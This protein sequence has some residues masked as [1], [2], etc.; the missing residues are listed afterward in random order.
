MPVVNHVVLASGAVVAVS[1]AVAAAMA[2]YENPELR[3]YAD[4][5]RRRIAVALHSLGDG[6]NPPNR[7]PRFNRPEDAEGFLQSSRGA[8]AEPGVDAD[9]ETRRR[10]REELLYWNSVLEQKKEQESARDQPAGL[11]APEPSRPRTGTRGTSFDD[12]LRQDESAEQGAY[13]FNTGADIRD[14]GS[15][16]R[17]RVPAAAPLASSSLYTNPFADEHYISNDEVDPLSRTFT[18]PRKEEHMSDIYSATTRENDDVQSRTLDG[19]PALIELS[20]SN[21]GAP[22]DQ[23]SSPPPPPTL[24]R[25]L[26]ENEYMSAGQEDRQDAYASIQAWAHDSSRNFYSPLP[27]TPV[28]PVSEP[29]V[30][31]DGQLT[32]T[33]S[34][35]IIGSGEDVGNDTRAGRPF[36]VMS[37]SEGMLTPASWSEVGSVVSETEGHAHVGANTP[38]HG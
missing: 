36:D 31:S 37:E 24:E 4:D 19:S 10:Q 22:Q 38:L 18:L 6:I 33:D 35:S 7:P 25:Q 15:G 23:F 32:P 1:V 3:R 29:E 8:G 14:G 34:I 2:M 20:S 17:H 13:V 30:V 9:E 12:F 21:F 28:A 11:P 16:L 27:E 26:G 5:I